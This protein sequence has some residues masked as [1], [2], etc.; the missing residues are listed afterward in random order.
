MSAVE[1]FF[2]GSLMCGLGLIIY[3]IVHD[4]DQTRQ[5]QEKSAEEPPWWH[6]GW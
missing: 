3:W 2:V 5:D 1:V 6:I 4:P